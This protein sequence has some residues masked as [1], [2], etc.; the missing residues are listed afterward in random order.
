MKLRIRQTK[1]VN[2]VHALDSAVFNYKEHHAVNT[3]DGSVWWIAYDG[4]TPV[5]YAGAVHLKD[6]GRVYLCRAGVLPAYRGLGLQRLLIRKRL[7]WAKTCGV[8]TVITYTDLDNVY[9]SNN[10]I[11]CGFKLYK[12]DLPWGNSDDALY[13]TRK[14]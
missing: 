14:V 2:V 12:P 5:A 10:L 7:T 3:A 9:S 1:D 8:S 13:W 6:K 11:D 4:K